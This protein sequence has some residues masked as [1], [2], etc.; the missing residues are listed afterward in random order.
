MTLRRSTRLLLASALLPLLACEGRPEEAAY[1]P[2]V[3][4]V[5]TLKV[6][7][8]SIVLHDEFPGRVSAFR[9]AEVRPQVG[10]LIR[11]RRFAEGDTVQKGQP[12]YQLEAAVFRAAVDGAAAAHAAS[13]AARLQAEL[14]A[15]RIQSLFE[16]GA[17]TQQASDDA[18]AALAIANAEVARARAALDRA[19]VDLDY[20]TIT[21]PIAGHIGIS[22][23]NEG[24]LVGP[25]DPTALSVIQQ[26]DR[27]FVDIKS[28][29]ERAVGLQSLQGDD[30]GAEVILLASTGAPYPERGRVQFAD[31]S[32]DP[33]SGELTVRALVP[34]A[35]RKLL[36][37][38]F[39]K[40]RVVLG[41]V[42]NAL[43]V[44]Q[45]AVL[46]DA[47]GQAQVFVVREDNTAEARNVRA[48]RI[49]SGRYLV[50]EGLSAGER[51]VVEGQDRLAPGQQI[52]P[53]EWQ[54]APASR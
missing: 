51:V 9:V 37:G 30:G 8:E 28:P 26:I 43:L 22:Q 44:P 49:I 42:A 12:L 2:P 23:V 3:Q 6:Q 35:Q 19:R 10:G 27:V 53:V 47:Q 17:S 31:I 13:E 14:H 16:K 4:E 29:V 15:G 39:V 45:Q 20:A 52:T 48:G 46:H 34:N 1:A 32:V 41:E 33:G 25:A 24:A 36:P 54:H 40:A 18:R 11:S 38:M 50:E 21:A 5:S 7:G